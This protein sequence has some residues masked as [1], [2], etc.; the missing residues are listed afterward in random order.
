MQKFFNVTASTTY[1]LGVCFVPEGLHVSAVCEKAAECGILLFDKNHKNGVKIPFPKANRKGNIYSM[2]LKGYQ[3]KNCSYLLYQDEN[4]YQDPYAYSLVNKRKYGEKKEFPARCKAPGR[5]YDWELDK[6]P[7]IP[8]EES[9]F[10]LLH[11]RGFTK[12]R[13]SGVHAKGTY[14]GI[15]E[16]I[17]YLK[18]LGI[19]AVLLMPAYEFDEILITKEQPLSMEQALATYKET[20]IDKEEKIRINYWGYQEGL[21]FLPKYAYSFQKDA[22]TEFKDMVKALHQNGIE[23]MMQFYFPPSVDSVT[24]LNILKYWVLEYHI[25]GFQL[26][27]IDIPMAMLCKDPLFAETKLLYDKNISPVSA[28]EAGG[29]QE[30]G[31]YRNFGLMNEAFL[32]DMRKLLKGDVNMINRLIYLNR[33]ND[34]NKG[35]VNYIAK[36]DGFRLYDLVSYD[37]KHNEANGESN[38]DGNSYNYSWNC[39]IEGKTRKKA[40]LDM[41]M[42]QM[43]NAL[44]FVFLSQGTPLLYSGDEFANSQDGNNNPYCQDNAVCWIK[45]N[46]SN[47]GEE[48]LRFT[49]Q[50][51]RFRKENP[52]L[53]SRMPL[54]G[55]DYLS[56]GYPDIS[57]HGK[58]AW[59]PETGVDSRSL[60]IMYCCRYADVSGRE[61]AFL[62]FGINMHWEPYKFALPQMPKDIEWI[63]L[64][65]TEASEQKEENNTKE[66]EALLQVSVPSRT[67]VVYGTRKKKAD[68][69]K[70][71]VAG[72][73][74]A[75]PGKS[76]RNKKR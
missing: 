10:Y 59:R 76:R 51:I 48:M 27:G 3:D 28:F 41:R 73:L 17:P 16:K 75:Q 61:D 8:Y 45:W 53:H 39:G 65:S 29:R 15:V 62:Y 2:L 25:D 67:I 31:A 12:H 34:V 50:L 42:R 44:T 14:A 68:D 33:E 55:M 9:I 6:A 71:T 47:M 22:V 63:K 35:I 30:S 20:L 26:M 58:D 40:I 72:H 11:V 18:E 7:L 56:C 54:R 43:K 57:L 1:P 70:E 23:V 32:Y 19:T 52:I 46:Q 13:S 69:G 4:I 60:G 49:K 37:K 66:T 64:F 38:Q 24:I 5:G 36:Q 21:Y 74:K